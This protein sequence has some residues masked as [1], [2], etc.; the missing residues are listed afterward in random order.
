MIEKFLEAQYQ[1]SEGK[2]KAGK[3]R[4]VG[5]KHRRDVEQTSPKTV[6]PSTM[7]SASRERALI[8]RLSKTDV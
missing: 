4:K 1:G 8:A 3:H 2:S 5:S 7:G 6:S